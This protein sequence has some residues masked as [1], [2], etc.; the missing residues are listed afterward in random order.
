[1]YPEFD[2]LLDKKYSYL[3]KSFLSRVMSWLHSRIFPLFFSYCSVSTEEP[4]RLQS[5]GS[6]RVGYD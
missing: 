3:I 1:M 6:L 2:I 4:G 5:M